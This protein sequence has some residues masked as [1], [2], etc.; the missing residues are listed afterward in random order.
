MT[1]SFPHS[2]GS[3]Q[4]ARRASRAEPPIRSAGAS[5]GAA[6]NS[7]GGASRAERPIRPAQGKP[8]RDPR[9]LRLSRMSWL[10]LGIH[11]AAHEEDAVMFGVADDEEERMVRF[12]GGRDAHG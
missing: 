4:S 2:P 9:R 6:T 12:E 11:Y 5:R 1:A 7:P 8:C 10:R 3:D